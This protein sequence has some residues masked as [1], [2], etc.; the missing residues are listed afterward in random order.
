VWI[1]LG[2]LGQ[3]VTALG[4][5]AR[6]SR[7]CCRRPTPWARQRSRCSWGWG[8]VGFALLWLALAVA[9]TVREFR[10]GLSFAPTWW[11]FIFPLG[12]CV[13]GTSALAARTGSPLF[14]GPALVH[15]GLLVIAWAIVALHSLVHASGHLARRPRP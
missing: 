11:S 9:L 10:A 14:S 4:A 13:T 12:A 6:A 7:G 15:Y 3:A 1:G 2:A 5:L 8:C